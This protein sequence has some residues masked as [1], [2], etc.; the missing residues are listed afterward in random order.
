MSLSSDSPKNFPMRSPN[1]C[2]LLKCHLLI[3]RQLNTT[4]P[5]LMMRPWFRLTLR[6]T[7]MMKE[8]LLIPSWVEWSSRRP[9]SS[10]KKKMFALLWLRV[11]FSKY[12]LIGRDVLGSTRMAHY[13]QGAMRLCTEGARW[14]RACARSAIFWF[15]TSKRGESLCL[16]FSPTPLVSTH[17]LN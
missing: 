5:R 4:A 11:R 8:V 14:S 10:R 2:L 6:V 9:K 1:K 17:K 15:T 3:C 16:L 7:Q 13:A 12:R